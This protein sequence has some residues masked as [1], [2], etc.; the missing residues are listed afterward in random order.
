VGV[1]A[2]IT[3][4]AGFIGSHLADA[5]VARGDEVVILDDLSTGR[6]ENIEHLLGEGRVQF[7]E[8]STLDA[9]L[10][11]EAMGSADICFHLASSVGV[12]LIVN[13][14]LGS[15]MR[16]VRG[17]NV[18]AFSAATQ[19]KRML[20]TSTSEM[21]GKWSDGLV[22]EDSD[23][24]LGP[25]SVS[26]WN[27]ATA[28]T[29]GEALAFGYHQERGAETIVV[30]IFNTVGPRQRG[31][32][33]MV[34]PRFVRQAL[35]GEDLTVYGDGMQSRCFTHVAD[36]VRALIALMESDDAIGQVFNV[37]SNRG[38][39]ILELAEKVIARTGSDSGIR[40][41]PYSEAYGDGFEDLG[42]RT[43]DTTKVRKL[44][45][46]QPELTIDDAIEGVVAFERQNAPDL[47]LS[48]S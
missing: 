37:G 12:K 44:T 32:Y 33:G 28:K 30:R 13:D 18:V 47:E 39:S 10:V 15:V 36:T 23:R 45:G 14:P 34:L 6:L 26:R 40:L 21:Y 9:E 3:G 2:L 48:A 4:G 17:V 43:P 41:V 5:L 1:K 29:F 11:D 42:H 8:G 20:F 19:G 22:S 24:L 16:D 27:Y 38:V 31:Q 25:A 35:T 7:V 46:W